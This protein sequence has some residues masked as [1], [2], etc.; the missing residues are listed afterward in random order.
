MFT[1][2]IA[3]FATL[4]IATEVS[5][6]NQPPGTPPTIL[7]TSTQEVLLD[8]IARDKHQKLITGLRQED[9]EVLEDG[10]PQ[11]LRSFEYRGA[12]HHA[13]RQNEPLLAR[14]G[15]STQ[16]LDE[17][18]L[19]SLV[20]EG[21][22]AESRREAAQAAKDF[23]NNV[24]PNTYIAVFV[25]NHRLSLLQQYTNDTDLLDRAVDRAMGGAYQQFAKDSEAEVSKLN[26]L[27]EQTRFQPLR[28]GSSEERG[29]QDAGR[30]ASAERQIARMTIQML[31][32]QVGNL[33]IDA[34]QQLIEAQ[35]QLPGRK[36]IVYFS[37][38]LILPPE[39]PERFRE[40]IGAAN[41]A[42][43]AFYT[44]DPTGLDTASSVR[45]SQL[46]SRA[47]R[48]VEADP[49]AKDANFKENLRNLAKE[50]GG[51]A[52]SDTN[53]ARVPLHRVMEEEVRSHYEV[54]YAPMSANYDGHFRAIEIR[55]RRPGVRV[56]GRK[57][58]FALPQLNGGPLAR[59]EFDALKALDSQPS[60]HAFDFHAGVFTF[61]SGAQSTECRAVFSVP[62]R[63]LHF[64]RDA[65]TKTFRVHVAFLALMK[66]D[67]DQVVGKLSR[68]LLFQAPADKQAE[69]ERG[70]MT[71]T[72]ALFL[73]PGRYHLEAVA[74]EPDGEAASTRK[75]ALVV[76][77][78]GAL[79]DLVLVRSVQPVEDRDALDPL[80]FAGGKITPELKAAVS[81]GNK[82]A[83]GVYFVL[84]RTDA[85]PDLRIAV[86]HD[87]K[88]VSSVRPALPAADA[89]GSVRVLS[90]IP[91]GGFDPGV[92]EV[93]VTAGSSRRSAV[94]EVQ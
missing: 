40:V 27:G 54:A 84:Y 79:S 30:F 17:M 3:V 1:R 9:V 78:A 52:I 14:T 19:V 22:G 4:A 32:N 51:F 53:D 93:T 94:I 64:I 66:D 39:Q 49:G 62:S 42:N 48:S 16:Q 56:Q 47:I 80:E 44:V 15:V 50:T 74:N 88:L 13:T 6:Q 69:F 61:R 63:G 11:T 29:P 18:N 76:P 82:A 57:G 86:T 10:V 87:G 67:H 7:R 2:A 70:E 38:G 60:P 28:S 36:T 5:P 20:F 59:F 77:A 34:L 43:V 25:L 72:L 35:A 31:A 41:R 46:T 21:L 12:G 73:A 68:D 8:F 65:K 75:V 26:S 83:Q 37:P 92:Y 90:A 58:Y 55:V 81:R 91:F 89:D 45:I 23:L 71:V 85:R 24:D 33:S